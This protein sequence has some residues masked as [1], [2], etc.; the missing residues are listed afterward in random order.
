MPE[1]SGMTHD[2]AVDALSKAGLG[3]ANNTFS[4]HGPKNGKVSRTEPASGS[5]VPPNSEIKIYAN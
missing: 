5:T 1:L 2:Q 3:N 4:W